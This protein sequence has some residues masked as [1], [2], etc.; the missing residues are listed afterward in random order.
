MK[1]LILVTGVLLVG[2][3]PQTE[4]MSGVPKAQTGDAPSVVSSEC[5]KLEE[6]IAQIAQTCGNGYNIVAT[7][8]RPSMYYGPIPV[9]KGTTVIAECN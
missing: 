7:E 8:Q 6:C 4:M 2:C 3:T 1:K 9:S 5:R